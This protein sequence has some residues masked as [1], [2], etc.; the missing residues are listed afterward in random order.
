MFN[1]DSSSL[2]VLKLSHTST[3]HGVLS[4]LI[5]T[6]VNLLEGMSCFCYRDIKPSH[7]CLITTLSHIL[8]WH[9]LT[10][11]NIIKILSLYHIP[12][13]AEHLYI[14]NLFAIQL[15]ALLSVALFLGKSLA[16]LIIIIDFVSGH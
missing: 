2:F 11:S 3:F 9:C 6:Q 13:L 10:F 7:N 1:Y 4:L 16:C 14:I 8:L 12:S 5:M 15:I